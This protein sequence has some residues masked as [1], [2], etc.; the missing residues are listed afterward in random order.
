MKILIREL[1]Y[2]IQTTFGNIVY[3]L[4]RNEPGTEEKNLHAISSEP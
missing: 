1:W 4:G 2:Q 3:F